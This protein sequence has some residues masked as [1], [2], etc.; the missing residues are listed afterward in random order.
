[1]QRWLPFE[2]FNEWRLIFASFFIIDPIYPLIKIFDFSGFVVDIVQHCHAL[3]EYIEYK[4]PELVVL[5]W[6]DIVTDI[7]IA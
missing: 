4:H 6:V 7:F 2:V 1:M 3:W 5:D